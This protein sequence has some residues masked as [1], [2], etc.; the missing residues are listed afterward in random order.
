M[1]KYSLNFNGQTGFLFEL[2]FNSPQ[3]FARIL[4]QRRLPRRH[5]CPRDECADTAPVSK[6][7][8]NLDRSSN[9]Y[10]ISPPIPSATFPAIF[11]KI[12]LFEAKTSAVESTNQSLFCHI[13]YKKAE[14]GNSKRPL[15][16]RLSQLHPSSAIILLQLKDKEK[17]KKHVYA[18]FTISLIQFT[19]SC[20]IAS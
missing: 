18:L 13:T 17:M 4:M 5:N 10:N 2:I 3:Q 16:G 1:Y 8:E 11:F 20:Y 9:Y 14:A 6:T 15:I 19:V 7:I 12:W